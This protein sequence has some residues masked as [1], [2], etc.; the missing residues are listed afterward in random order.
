[1][2]FIVAIVEAQTFAASR[3]EEATASSPTARVREIAAARHA[4]SSYKTPEKRAQM[5]AFMRR[6]G[7]AN[8]RRD[9]AAKRERRY[10]AEHHARTVWS[11]PDWHMQSTVSRR[12]FGHKAV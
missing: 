6:E 10:A 7:H 4:K 8:V 12:A 9:L 3:A 5:A 11:N 2:C 1:M